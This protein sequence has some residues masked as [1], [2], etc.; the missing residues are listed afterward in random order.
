[1]SKSAKVDAK[2]LAAAERRK[3]AAEMR[4][5]GHTY[6]EIAVALKYSHRSMAKQA[7][8]QYRQELPA[9]A[10]EDLRRDELA[11]LQKAHKAAA[12]LLE[13]ADPK[14]ALDAVAKVAKVSDS[15]ARTAGIVKLAPVVNLP[16]PSRELD[17]SML[18][19]D[20]LMELHRIQTKMAE[21]KKEEPKT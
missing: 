21:A 20:D 8:D 7:I 3:R 10:I 19:P 13:H 18:S 16:A 5:A 17:T 1:M 6:E 4:I 2:R 12:K 9:E 15:A 14:V 11:K